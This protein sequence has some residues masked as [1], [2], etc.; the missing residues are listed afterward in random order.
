MNDLIQALRDYEGPW[1]FWVCR[2]CRGCVSWR[3]EGEYHI[4]TCD[5]CGEE[6]VPMSVK[7]VKE[8]VKKSDI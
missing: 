3:R 1:F 8:S 5:E 2:K 7:P 6:S 4:A